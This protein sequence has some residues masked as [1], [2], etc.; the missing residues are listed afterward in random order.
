M[1]PI[2]E[3]IDRMLSVKEAAALI[4]MRP[5]TLDKWRSAG[6]PNAPAFCRVGRSC[7]YKLSTLRAWMANQE[8]RFSN[9]KKAA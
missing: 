3:E 5:Q 6:N 2:T 9:H 8:D 7:R 1:A 4:G